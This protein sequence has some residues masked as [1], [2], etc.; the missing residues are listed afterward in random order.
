MDTKDSKP[1]HGTFRRTLAATTSAALLMTFAATAGLSAAGAIGPSTPLIGAAQQVPALIQVAQATT[2]E[3]DEIRS[4]IEQAGDGDKDASLALAKH[5]ASGAEPDHETA[6]KYA[7]IALADG[8]QKYAAPFVSNTRAWPRDFWRML[9][10]ELLTNGDYSSTIDGLPGPGTQRAVWAHAGTK[11]P[12][13]T[14]RVK[15]KYRKK[16]PRGSHSN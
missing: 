8:G 10:L 6:A 9:Q 2:P 3:S 16:V 13:T 11:P 12:V 7:M 4:L 14:Q 1:P 5:Y 15:R